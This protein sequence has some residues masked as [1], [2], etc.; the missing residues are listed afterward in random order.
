MTSITITI[1]K[2]TAATLIAAA[3][4]V[5]K[6]AELF[7]SNGN[8][9]EKKAL[10]EMKGVL[11]GKAVSAE[12]FEQ[13]TAADEKPELKATEVRGFDLKIGRKTETIVKVV[14]DKATGQRMV[15]TEAGNQYP[16][17]A[18]EKVRGALRLT[19]INAPKAPA[20]VKAGG[21]KAKAQVKPVAA[22][23]SEVRGAQVLVVKGSKSK[24]VTITKVVRRDDIRYAITEGG[25]A[26]QLEL[27]VK[28]AD[29]S[30]AY[31]GKVTAAEL[32]EA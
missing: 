31:K 4:K 11:S 14:R 30:F 2:E 18:I 17:A 1:S 7:G 9:P 22:Q 8:A 13:E 5:I 26:L 20:N 10:A 25:V 19:E 3:D 12:G 6:V 28:N 27:I 21:V 23:A 32:R 15:V 29:G 16:L 24:E